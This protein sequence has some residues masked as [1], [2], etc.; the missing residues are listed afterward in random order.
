MSGR[1]GAELRARRHSRVR[2]KVIGTAERPRL[3]VFRS[4]KHVVAQIIDDGTGRTLVSASSVADLKGNST[5]NIEAALAVGKLIGERAKAAGIETVVFDRG[6][7][8]Y[9]GRIAAIAEGA[10]AGGLKF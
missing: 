10:R 9:H 5:S 8:L 3:S 7:F 2:K 1:T 4:N 6:G